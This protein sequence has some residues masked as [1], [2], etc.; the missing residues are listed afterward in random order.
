MKIKFTSKNKNIILALGAESAGN[1]SVYQNGKIFLSKNFGDL[2]EEKNFTTFKKSVLGYFKKNNLTP[3]IIL[4]DYHPLYK[5]TTLGL[6][7]AKK[8]KITLI[9]IQ[10]HLAHIFS[11]YGENQDPRARE[12]IGIACDGTGL[13]LDGK[14]W[15]GEIFQFS[16]TPP[17]LQGGVGGSFQLLTKRIGKLENQIMT[18]GDLAIR[19]PCRMLISIL[20]KFLD[21]EKIYKNNVIKKLY[22]KNE[23]ELLYSQLKNNFN[24]Q[25]TSSTGRILD[26]ASV[27]L[28]FCDN[29]RNYKHEPIDLLEKNS[30]TPYNIEPQIKQIKKNFYEL[31]T[32]P[33]FQYLFKNINLNKKRLAATAQ[34][35][36]AKG[37]YKIAEHLRQ[38]DYAMPI[39][40]AGGIANNKIISFYLKSKGVI[41]NK[42]IARGDAGIS[43][44][45]VVFCLLN[46]NR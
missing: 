23:F 9:K 30:S 22:S 31:E 41:A 34:I 26:A 5:T 15:G 43:F 42:K 1:F 12:F 20:S 17:P 16:I 4:T 36:L 18:G 27:F 44:G 8:Y 40:F 3:D 35:Y 11:A 37:L 32:T 25:E 6:I 38:S 33:L 29:K 21:K 10:H 19:E 28:G 7:L 14:I 24:C 13:G 2:L 39:Y 45:Q 46:N